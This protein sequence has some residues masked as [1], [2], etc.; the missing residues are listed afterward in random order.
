MGNTQVDISLEATIT[1]ESQDKSDNVEMRLASPKTSNSLFSA[2]TSRSDFPSSMDKNT[3]CS[4]RV[5]R[6]FLDHARF[7]GLS[8]EVG[9][10]RSL[11][12]AEEN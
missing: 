12:R 8:R 5:T 3:S 2:V 10:E 6:T 4:G 9:H 1:N 7:A 11:L